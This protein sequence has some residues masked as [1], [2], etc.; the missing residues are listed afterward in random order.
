MRSHW[1]IFVAAALVFWSRQAYGAHI[2]VLLRGEEARKHLAESS[3]A[4][5]VAVQAATD[6]ETVMHLLAED[7][8]IAL[9]TAAN[10]LVYIDSGLALQHDHRLTTGVSNAG[11]FAGPPS[12]LSSSA[13]RAGSA[14]DQKTDT[15][16]AFKLHSRPSS[17]MKIYLD[18][19]GHKTEN[20]LWNNPKQPSIYTPPFSQDAD[21]AFSQIELQAIMTIWRAVAEDFSIFDVDVT[22]EEPPQFV[23]PTGDKIPGVRVVIGGSSADWLGSS[24]GGIAFIGAFESYR[25]QPCF[26]FSVELGNGIPKAVW[27]AVSHEG[28]GCGLFCMHV[29]KCRNNR[30]SCTNLSP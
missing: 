14:A 12:L 19:D 4:A 24:A 20:T 13:S 15:T 28:E 11:N 6:Q 9:D 8:D 23:N 26:V 18:F 27:E 2:D 7:A 25:L 22:T 10:A 1:C 3:L 29:Y 16:L 30:V 21:D 17:S 5:E